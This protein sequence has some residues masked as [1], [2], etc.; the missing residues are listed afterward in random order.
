CDALGA[1]HRGLPYSDSPG[2]PGSRPHSTEPATSWPSM[3]FSAP[4]VKP[5]KP[6]VSAVVRGCQQGLEEAEGSR[7]EL[8]CRASTEAGQD[9]DN[10]LDGSVDLVPF[11]SS[12]KGARLQGRPVRGAAYPGGGGRA[13]ASG[14]RGRALLRR[15]GAASPLRPPV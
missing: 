10:A 11:R 8:R 9:Q 15:T 6:L 3:P 5:D 7:P 13:G 4:R 12:S 2:S 1:V 14:R